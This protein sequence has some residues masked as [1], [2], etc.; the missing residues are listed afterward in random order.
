M[1]SDSFMQDN[2]WIMVM[3]VLLFTAFVGGI[4]NKNIDPNEIEEDEE[5]E[6]EDEFKSNNTNEDK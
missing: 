4:L 5:E 6:E 3:V 1:I 2:L